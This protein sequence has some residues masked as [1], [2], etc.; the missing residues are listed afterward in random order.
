MNEAL[1]CFNN[2]KL[3]HLAAMFATLSRKQT[4]NTAAL[5]NAMDTRNLARE[6]GLIQF[7][8]NTVIHPTDATMALLATSYA[9]ENWYVPGSI[10]AKVYGHSPFSPPQKGKYPLTSKVLLGIKSCRVLEKPVGVVLG[11]DILQIFNSSLNPEEN[12]YDLLLVSFD[13]I[14]TTTFCTTGELALRLNKPGALSSVITL[15]M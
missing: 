13:W 4:T 14:C 7:L 12:F 3:I 2:P 5:R 8:P 1:P 11:K 9:L 15:D 10:S 6:L